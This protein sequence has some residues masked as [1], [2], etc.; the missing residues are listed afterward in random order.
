MV[1][2]EAMAYGCI[3]CAFASFEAIEDIID[4]GHSG[5]LSYSLD[6][7]DMADM[8]SSAAT[9]TE[10]MGM[11]AHNATVKIAEFSPERIAGKW[12]MLFNELLSHHGS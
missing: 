11:M 4:N 1:L 12:I 8:M 5:L 10:D 3:P 6:P 7:A 9:K 2:P